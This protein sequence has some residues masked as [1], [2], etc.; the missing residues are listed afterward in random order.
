M[1][2]IA[3]ATIAVFARGVDAAPDRRHATT[4]EC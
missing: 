4:A 1:P 3:P 2:A